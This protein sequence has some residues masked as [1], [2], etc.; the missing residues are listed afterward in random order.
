[1]ISVNIW[2]RNAD[3]STIKSFYLWTQIVFSFV[4][5]LLSFIYVLWFSVYNSSISLAELIP[6]YFIIFVAITNGIVFLREF[7]LSVYKCNYF[8][9][10]FISCNSLNSF[11]SSTS[12]FGVDFSVFC[13]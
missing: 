12:F 5:S 11:V 2:A 7:A 13:I 6:K 8:Y 1:M 3:L 4:S 10:V 9:V